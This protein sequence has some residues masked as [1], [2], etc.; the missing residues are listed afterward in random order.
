[1]D[2]HRLKSRCY[3]Y[4]SPDFHD[5]DHRTRFYLIFTNLLVILITKKNCHPCYPIHP[6]LESWFDHVWS[7]SFLAP[8]VPPFTSQV[9]VPSAVQPCLRLPR[10]DRCSSRH[11]GPGGCCDHRHR[12]SSRL[13]LQWGLPKP[14]GLGSWTGIVGY[15]LWMKNGDLMGMSWIS[16]GFWYGFTG[17]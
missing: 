6:N 13:P 8:T 10:G 15:E 17:I 12:C 2:V 4:R 7:T 14:E 5:I 3:R 9:M 11:R 1:M 16:L